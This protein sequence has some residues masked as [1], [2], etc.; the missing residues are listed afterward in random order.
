LRVLLKAGMVRAKAQGK[1]IARTPI[2]KKMQA[3]IA[4]LHAQGLS[5][6]Q[7]SKQPGIGYGTAWN[8]VKR[9]KA[10]QVIPQ[11]QSE[12]DRLRS[13]RA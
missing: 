5:I 3:R 12:E 11:N 13:L 2:P 1:R 10:V 4:V 7:I 8:Y 6:S 9:P